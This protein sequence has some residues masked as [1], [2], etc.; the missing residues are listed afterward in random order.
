MSADWNTLITSGAYIG[1]EMQ[2]EFG[3]IPPSFLPIGAAFLV[4]H[5]LREA[6]ERR[7]IWLSLPNDYVMTASQQRLLEDND[8][9]VFRAEPRKSLG[10]SVFQA[11]LEIGPDHPLEIMHGDTL[12]LNPAL[13]ETDTVSVSKVTEQFKWGLVEADDW[14]IRSVQDVDRSDTI[15]SDALI[16]S[17]YF[18]IREPWRLLKCLVARDF[19]F[20]GALDAYASEVPVA[21]NNDMFTLDFGHLKTYYDSRR[22]LAAARHFNSISIE[23]GVVLKRSRDRRKID[24]EANWLRSIPADLQPYSARLIENPGAPPRGEYRTLYSS[25]PT[26]AELYLARTPRVV[27]RKV[28]RSCLDY[29]GKAASHTDLERK[30][31]FT[32][33]VIGKLRE[34]VAQY[35]EFLPKPNVPLTINGKSVGTLE[36]IVARLAEIIADAPKRP[37]CIMHGDFCFANMLYDLRS[38]RIQLIDP[39]GLITDEVT[40]HGD[41]RYDIAK[42]GHSILGRYDQILGEKLLAGGAGADFTLDIAPD[43][44]REWLEKVFLDARVADQRFDA[45][46]VMAAVVS[47]F[48]SMIPLHADDPNRQRA[49]FAKGLKLY[50]RFFAL[51]G[52]NGTV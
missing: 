51:S 2:A 19:S 40:I 43:P 3:R 6:K 13:P 1:E 7:N 11:I 4:Q 38:D 8:V 33:L 15:S 27:W 22:N 49:L 26:L 29:L 5:Q 14:Q 20:T 34:R 18:A 52:E 28:L 42:L 50:L 30:E 17:G 48:L 31:T 36:S 25:Y 24:A 37:S 23:G 47:L 44:T 41:L 32:W 35:P 39:R 45:P 9:H 21:M 46:E 12:V 16:L 10:M